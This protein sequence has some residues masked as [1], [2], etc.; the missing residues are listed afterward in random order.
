MCV[1]V[2]V[3]V[4]TCVGW[5]VVFYAILIVVGYLMP[6][7]VY[8]Y[9]YIKTCYGEH[10]TD[11]TLENWLTCLITK[12]QKRKGKLWTCTYANNAKTQIDYILNGMIAHWIARHIPLLRVCSP[13]IEVPR[14]RYDWAYEKMWPEQPQPYTMTGLCL[15]TGILGINIR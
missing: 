9:I 2:G 3:C 12:F 6:N 14:L 15:T 11:F 5:L 10:P 4:K 13:I 8:I 1:C 7:P